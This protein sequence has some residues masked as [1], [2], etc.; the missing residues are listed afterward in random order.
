[1]GAAA[2]GLPL[3]PDRET[4]RG[5][6]GECGSEDDVDDPYRQSPKEAEMH[7]RG[8]GIDLQ[9]CWSRQEGAPSDLRAVRIEIDRLAAGQAARQTDFN[10][11]TRALGAGA[12]DSNIVQM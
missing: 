12:L 4:G 7:F 10:F 5:H 9:P 1:M 2:L 6:E 11:D 8:R 3:E